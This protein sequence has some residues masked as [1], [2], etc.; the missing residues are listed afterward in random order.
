MT[1]FLTHVPWAAVAVLAGLAV[2]T[3]RSRRRMAALPVLDPASHADSAPSPDGWHLISARGVD[4][5]DATLRAAVAHADRTGLQILDLIPGRLDTER[6]LGLLRVL[7]RSASRYGRTAEARGAG[8]ALLI[9]EDVRHRAEIEPDSPAPETAEL[10]TLLRRL[11]AYAPD[12]TGVAIAPALASPA[13]DSARR[14]AELRAQGLPPNLVIASQLAGLA[15]LVGA[16][17]VDGGWGI[18]A[19]ALYWLQPAL[20][21]G[22]PGS[23]L[24]PADLT[25]ATAARPLLSLVAALRTAVSSHRASSGPLPELD[26]LRPGYD[27]ELKAGTDRFF[28][29]RRLD[30]PWCGS[31]DLSV[32]LRVPDL[33]Q[34]KPGRFTLEECGMCG[35]VFQNP[36]LSLDGLD[37]YYRDFYEGLGVSGAAQVFGTMGRSYRARAAMLKPYG[38]PT[39]WLDVG[40][41]HG[42]F[43]DSA[44]D[45]WPGTL[46][47]GLDMSAAVR[48]AE[49]RGWVG[50]AHHGQFP[51]LA[52][53]LVHRY[54]AVSMYHYLEHTREPLTELD[55][56]AAVLP[57]GGHLL[58]ELPDPES[59]LG[60]ILGSHWLPW[61][62][63]QHQHLIPIGNLRQA[64][65]DRGFTVLAEEH[66][67]A[68]QSCDFVGAVLLTANRLAPHPYAP[69]GPGTATRTRRAVR[70]VVHTAAL[71]CY[72]V[73]AALDAVRAAVARATEGGNAYRLLARRTPAASEA[74]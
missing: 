71:P 74:A 66:G 27:A 33:L 5:D 15:L 49:A 42:H 73:A 12:A 46:F 6:A 19:A 44:R 13:P 62:Q 67:A 48:E 69:W 51:D 7:D 61:F 70:R 40:T 17:V 20:V 58:I 72:V 16:V 35:H 63:P 37:F 2:G 36:R 34:G 25:R 10:H 28:E 1:S 52:A 64:L 32:R 60:R 29:P 38:T 43:C 9:A 59:R 56:A 41:G 30:C 26:A 47:D 57:P 8:H 24:R 3:L 54:D 18:A 50:T 68:H 53:G 65:A 11:K 4:V 23:P 45:I 31:A 21:L 39:A 22:A 14:A 55:A